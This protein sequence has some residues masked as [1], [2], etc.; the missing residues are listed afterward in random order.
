[1]S[2][3]DWFDEYEWRA[4]GAGDPERALLG[5]L[6]RDA[7][8]FRESD[9]DRALALVA[10]GRALAERL[11]EPWWVLYYDQQRVHALLHFKQDYRGVLELAVANTLE[12]RKPAY[13]GFPRRLLIHGDLV[14]AYLGIDPLGH[15]A[16]IRAA[17]DYLDAETPA[18]GDDRY[19][20]LGSQRQ[21]AL[22]RGRLDEAEDYSRRSLAL[23]A[24]DPDGGR[25]SHFSVFTYSGLCEVGWRKGDRELLAAAALAGEEAARV[26]GHQVELAGFWLWLALLYRQEGDAGRAGQFYRQAARRLAGLRMPRDPSL[27]D[28]ECAYHEL[29]GRPEL[30][31][32]ARDDELAEL[33]G[34]GRS[35]QEFACLLKRAWL[36]RRLGRLGEADLDRARGA[37]ARLR[38]PSR[39]L[40]ELKK[41]VEG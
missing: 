36:L 34:R 37:A 16:A 41:L 12:V 32:A 5:E 30:A 19:L 35:A 28:A 22:E 25:A 40:E 20:L 27:R 17:L 2:A 18:E 26:V 15:A 10:R 33:A 9:P 23:A 24:G 14:S 13:A 31:L 7:Y 11:G 29:A 8:H 4:R 1:M 21:F 38:E 39:Y 3:W 6:H